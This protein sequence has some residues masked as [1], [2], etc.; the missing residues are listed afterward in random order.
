MG[1]LRTA[2]QLEDAF[3]QS[4][5]QQVFRLAVEGARTTGRG[6]VIV[7][8]ISDDKINIEYSVRGAVVSLLDVNDVDE[9][10]VGDAWERMAAYDPENEFVVAYLAAESLAFD[11]VAP[12][13]A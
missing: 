11:T 2:Q 9:E 5:P 8:A 12:A 4:N 3:Q 1:E 10:V 13:G 7:R 6:A